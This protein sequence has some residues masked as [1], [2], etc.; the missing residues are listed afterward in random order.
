MTRFAWT[1]SLLSVF[2]LG[3]GCDVE[4]AQPHRADPRGELEVCEAI[5]ASEPCAIGEAE[6]VRYCDSIGGEQRW[7]ACL[8]DVACTPGE[9]EDC[10]LCDAD[11]EECDFAGWTMSCWLEE[12]VPTTDYEACNTPLVLSFDGAEAQMSPAAASTFDI[13][14]A[15]GCITTD[16]PGA[17]TP[18]L[19]LDRD[20]SGSIEDGREL[21]GSGTRLASGGRAS[22]GFLALSDLDEN[23]DG[24]ID[25]R[26]AAFADLVL[27]S[28]HD[29]SKTSTLA[30]MEPLAM[31]GVLSIELG[32]D[33]APECDDRGNCGVQRAEFTFIERG[34]E[35]RTG[36]VID[37]H[38]SCQ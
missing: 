24:R 33:V 25:A 11:D 28:D 19:A 14:A 21:F 15:G 12:G 13:N 18:W 27:W 5:G 23:R 16:W 32:Y 30:E 2:A 37:V 35:V 7:G 22:N 26:D 36:A 10:G 4:V 38:L 1:L 17:S 3:T 6:G 20:G 31:R 34:G 29:A 8:E 9:E